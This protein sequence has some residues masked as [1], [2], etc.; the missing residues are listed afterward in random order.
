MPQGMGY[1]HFLLHPHLELGG[2]GVLY[3]YPTL[4]LMQ[5]Y[6]QLIGFNTSVYEYFVEQYNLCGY[7][8]TLHYPAMSEYPALRD[9]W[10]SVP[11]TSSTKQMKRELVG[12]LELYESLDPMERSLVKRQSSQPGGRSFA[13]TGTIDSEYKCNIYGFLLQYARNYTEPWRK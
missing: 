3:Q 2:P 9:D 4:S 13:L 6:P 8:L 10:T 7:N 11:T 5:T 12:I 1:L